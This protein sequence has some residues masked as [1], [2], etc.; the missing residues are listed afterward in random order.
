MPT[1][2]LSAFDAVNGTPVTI[3][4]GTFNFAETIHRWIEFAVGGACDHWR[5]VCMDE[6]LLRWMQGRGHGE[7]A[8]YYY[9]LLPGAPRYDFANLQRK[10][11]MPALMPL[12]TRLFL[13]LARAGRDFIHSD[14]DAFWVRDP[15]P[16]LVR[17]AQ[18]DLLMS[19]GTKY[20]YEQY[21]RHRFVLCAG[22]FL[23]RANDRTRAF[24]ERVEALVSRNPLDQWGMNQVLLGDPEGHWEVSKPVWRFRLGKKSTWR[25]LS[26]GMR[27]LLS[28]LIRL[29]VLHWRIRHLGTLCIVTSGEIMRG[30][31][32]NALSVGVIPMRL[33]TRSRVT[34]TCDYVWH[35]KGERG[36]LTARR[37][38]STHGEPVR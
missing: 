32:S 5:I 21:R 29:L 13:H 14:A 18:F 26:P 23:C 28:P 30:P 34:P 11:L 19:Q 22:F 7:Q 1:D 37:L 6:E 35:E 3:V 16:W 31:F 33:V 24:F 15:R 17:H 4:F 10:L 9:D 8:V 27:T 25:R 12:R 20:P 36:W 2:S 38:R